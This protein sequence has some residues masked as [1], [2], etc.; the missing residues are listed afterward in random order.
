MLGTIL[1]VNKKTHKPC[2]HDYYIG[3]PS[4]LGNPYIITRGNMPGHGTRDVVIGSYE[5]WLHKMIQEAHYPITREI[6][7]LFKQYEA[8]NTIHLVCWCAPLHCHGD[9]IKKR[10]EDIAVVINLYEG[11]EDGKHQ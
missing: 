9:V 1:V 4:P 2:A 8:G 5:R 11:E 10:I 3:R 7:E 6:N